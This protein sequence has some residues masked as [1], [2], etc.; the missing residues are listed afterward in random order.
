MMDVFDNEANPAARARLWETI[1]ATPNLDWQ[2][3]TKRAPNIA[4]YLPQDWNDGYPNVWLGVTCENRKHGLP[5]VDILRQ[6]PAVVRFV[7]AEPLLEDISE[8]DLSGIDWLIVGGESGFGYRPM[9]PEWARS[10]R[11]R[12]ATTGV[13]FFYKQDGGLHGGGHL[14]DGMQYYN[15]PIPHRLS[16]AA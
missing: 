11:D 12:C 8:I 10:L 1:R 6:I 16:H 15:W 5:R 7:S 3:L 4:K 14:L 13:T 9:N 2:L